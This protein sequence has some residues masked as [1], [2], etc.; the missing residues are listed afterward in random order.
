MVLCRLLCV[1]RLLSMS[2]LLENQ[3]GRKSRYLSNTGSYGAG[4]GGQKNGG[5]GS[6][7][8]GSV[9]V[10]VREEDSDGK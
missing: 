5:G 1:A 4:G 8:V 6:G 3:H 7:G 2:E 10:G 9:V